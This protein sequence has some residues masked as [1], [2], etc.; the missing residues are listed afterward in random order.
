[1][2]ANPSLQSRTTHSVEEY[3]AID[4]AGEGK[5]EYLSGRILA[6]G[7]ASSRHVLI[8]TNTAREL[9]NQLRDTRCQVY[10]SDLRIQA[11]RGNAF[12]YPDVAVVCE[13][14]EYRDARKDTVTNPIVIVEV[15]SRST[16]NY[17]R[18]EKFRSYRRLDS[19]REYL[20]ID[21]EPCHIEHFVRRGEIWE[22]SETDA[23]A[24]ELALPSLDIS[25]PIAEIYSKV[26]LLE[27]EPEREEEIGQ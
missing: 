14:P 24:G 8:A 12:H 2:S 25:L 19:L 7:G 17:D 5:R 13:R 4:R 9:R 1:M 16:R 15:L 27:P 26:D 18:G 10:S 11:D 6:L 20:L 21:Q 23:F 22:F 3:L